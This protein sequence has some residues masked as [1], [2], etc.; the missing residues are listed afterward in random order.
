MKP[1][2][3]KIIY[4]GSGDLAAENLKLLSDYFDFEA[5]ITK[6]RKNN[7]QKELPVFDLAEKLNIPVFFASNR[8]EVDEIFDNNRFQSDTGLLI[9][10]GIII[11]TKVIDCFEKGIINSHFSILPEWRGPDPITYTILSGQTYAG[12][13]LM[14]IVERMDEGPLLAYEEIP[15]DNKINNQSLS[16]K[17][18]NLSCSLLRKTLPEYIDGKIGLISQEETGKK[19]SYSKMIHKT[20]GNIDFTLSAELIDRKIR[21]FSIWPKTRIRFFDSDLIITKASLL[22]SQGQPGHFFVYNNMLAFFCSK[23]S[24]IIEELIPAGKKKMSSRDYLLGRSDL[25][26]KISV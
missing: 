3:K 22:R 8:K 2:S 14:K 21:A 19:T 17:L 26:K 24:I 13:S 20:D 16:D 12:V 7:I 25:V 4:F 6:P 1:T 18:V 10:F 5:I 23:D 9:D 15:I 11:S